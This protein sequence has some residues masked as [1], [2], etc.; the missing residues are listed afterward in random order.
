MTVTDA[1]GRE[2]FEYVYNLGELVLRTESIDAGLR[3]QVYDPIG[4]LIET[5][6]GKGALI[7]SSFD[8][9]NRPSEVWA[10][11]KSG[12]TVTLR[13]RLE[14][15][16]EGTPNQAPAARQVQRA[17]NRLGKL[18]RHFDEA[19][20]LTFE[21]YDF[22]GNILE[23]YRQVFSDEVI[24]D[25]LEEADQAFRPDWM[26]VTPDAGLDPVVYQTTASYDALGRVKA[27]I[28]PRGCRGN[29]SD[30]KAALR[31]R[32]CVAIGSAR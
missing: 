12:D 32:R 10:R 16:D 15:G 17:A 14:Y 31:P 8:R 13:E 9:L 19:G 18:H 28:Y 4:N 22:Q 27:M 30:S 23:K 1:L 2:A 25:A 29:S 20:L 3:H 7:L 26:V 6:D 21:A 11:D 5:R 24:L